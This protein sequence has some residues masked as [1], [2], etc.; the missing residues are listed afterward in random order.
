[1][2]PVDWLETPLATEADIDAAERQ[3]ELED[4]AHARLP[5]PADVDLFGESLADEVSRRKIASARNDVRNFRRRMALAG[6]SPLDV[7]ARCMLRAYEDGDYDK[8]H[9]RARD[10]APYLAPRLSV[11]A[12]PAAVLTPSGAAGAVRFTWE[13]AES[14]PAPE[15]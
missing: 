9:E 6:V 13:A 10:L 1:M 15:K 7:M 4:Q 2:N 8:A 11:I 12:S 5:I 3:A 14:L